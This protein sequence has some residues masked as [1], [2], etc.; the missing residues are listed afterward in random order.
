M[1]SASFA[2]QS[3]AAPLSSCCSST[4]G[5]VYISSSVVAGS[6]VGRYGAVPIVPKEESIS[7]G[8][9]GPNKLATT[10]DVS[11]LRSTHSMYKSSKYCNDTM[12]VIF[13]D[14]NVAA[15]NYRSLEVEKVGTRTN[16]VKGEMYKAKYMM[17]IL[18][19][20]MS[21]TTDMFRCMA[22]G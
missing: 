11:D 19:L 4:W 15:L 18:S 13:E 6:M 10:V 3:A 22:P 21:T 9:G 17:C 2:L 14:F 20:L 1:L 5:S 8:L 16:L 7:N 12:T